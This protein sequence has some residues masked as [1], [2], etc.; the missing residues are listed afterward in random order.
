M[1]RY[2]IIF[3]VFISILTVSAQNT[4]IER[5]RIKLGSEISDTSRCKTF[6]SLSMFNMFFTDRSD[7]TLNYCNEYVKTA[8]QIPDK[9]Y[10][11]LAYARLSFYFNNIGQYKESLNTAFKGLDL[12]EQYHIQDYLSVLYYNLSWFYLNSNDSKEGLASALK[13]IAFLKFNKD[14]FFD[15][16]LH[17]YGITGNLY[18]NL[19]K[20][21]SALIY[22]GQMDSIAANSTE[23]AAKTIT[24]WYWSQYYLYFRKDY[25]KT[26]SV[27]AEA[28]IE[29]RKYGMFLI[30]FFYLFS[31]TSYLEQGK[32]EK[33]I[34]EGRMAYA[35]SLPIT[36]PEGERFA[37]GL[38]NTC[39]ERSGNLDSAY[40]Y[41]KLKDSLSDL[42]QVHS[43]A[44]EI[45]QFRSDQQLSKKEEEAAAVLQGQKNRG[46]ILI[47]V[48][49]TAVL[50][51]LFI[52]LIQWRNNSQRKKANAVLQQQKQ[53]VETTLQELKST[54]AQ[55]IHS[56]KM[57]SLGE[58]TAGIAHEIQ[59]PLNFV[60]N[61]SEINKELIGE[62][63]EEIKKGN[64]GEVH[65]IA[66]DIEANEEKIN[67][68]GKRADAIVKGMLQHSRSSS[69]LKE[70]TDLNKLADEYLKLAYFGL[71]AKVKDFTATIKTDFDHTI[72]KINIIPQDIGRV[73][74]NIYNNAFYALSEMKKQIGEGYEPTISVTT[75]KTENKVYLSVL[76]NGNGIPPKI[77]DKIFQPFFTTKPTGQGTGLGLS[78][79]YDIL[80]AHGGEIKVKTSENEGSEF[81]I[82][83][84]LI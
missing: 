80:K 7:S 16:A 26:D 14:P 54:Q 10:L 61:F 75:K 34:A 81:I 84:P 53:K 40:H 6:D 60:N 65:A 15:Q 64:I 18:L 55:L 57:A 69:N 51:F 36:D 78:L 43:N 22:Y 73:F 30:N 23:L 5:L 58:L 1:K 27:C 76:D 35:L 11:I 79:S 8:F 83:L 47:Y 62:L 77:I 13:G 37:A 25:K 82:E 12:S 32:I 33:A 66:Q 56:E 71:R 52:A 31:S 42:I 68:H 70:P 17:L 41:L 29:C 50:F 45:Q 44:I 67:H 20:M 4:T 74:L 72:G 3:F 49:S 28:I 24:D 39:Y 38:L 48:F 2:T 46:R 63:N 21:D 19:N 9:K 59:N